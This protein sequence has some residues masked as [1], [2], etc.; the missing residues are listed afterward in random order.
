MVVERTYLDP[1]RVARFVIRCQHCKAAMVL[2]RNSGLYVPDKCPHCPGTWS[3]E[4]SAINRLLSDLREVAEQQR[5]SPVPSDGPA[6]RI[7]FEINGQ[8]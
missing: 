5:I 1:V 4:A 6:L 3:D 7:E 2:P 8:P